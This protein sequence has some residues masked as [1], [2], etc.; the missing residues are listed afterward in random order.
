MS[1]PPPQIDADLDGGCIDFERRLNERLDKR[2]P[3]GDLATAKHLQRCAK[4]QVSFDVYQ[5]FADHDG[6]VLNANNRIDLSS[7]KPGH[8]KPVSTDSFG[9][10]LKLAIIPAT[11]AAAALLI[12]FNISTTPNNDGDDVASSAAT[13]AI[14]MP[15][16]PIKNSVSTL[17]QQ[18]RAVIPEGSA[19]A[20]RPLGA[21]ANSKGLI[22]LPSEIAF[23]QHNPISDLSRGLMAYRLPSPLDRFPPPLRYTSELPGVRPIHRTIHIA[24]TAIAVQNR[25]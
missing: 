7:S 3:V 18:Y 17:A 22:E 10:N 16:R 14:S 23:S 20:K 24:M 9:H 4:C 13:Q 2:V 21:T 8:L 15:S 25:P 6:A 19:Q 11:L 12:F 1:K 5:Q